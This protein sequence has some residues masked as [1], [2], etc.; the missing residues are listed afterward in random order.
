M[1][2]AGSKP[3]ERLALIAIAALALMW[4]AAVNGGPF[5]TT[6]SI[7]YIR[8]PDQAV[9]KLFG[10]GHA[11]AWSAKPMGMGFHRGAVASS[12]KDEGKTPPMAGR[13]IYYGLLANLG[14]RAGGFWLTIALQA[15]ATAFA[16]S[17]LCRS[18]GWE[19]A[20]SYQGVAALATP[21]H[22]PRLLRLLHHAGCLGADPD[23][24][25]RGAGGRWRAPVAW[26][27]A[28]AVLTAAPGLRGRRAHATH[29]LLLAAIAGAG[30]ILIGSRGRLRLRLG[31]AGLMAGA[32]LLALS[33]GA[34]SL[35]AF[36]V[37]VTRVY[38]AP[39]VQPPVPDRA[40][41]LATHG[42]ARLGW[43]C[44]ARP[45]GF[46]ACAY[47]GR[48][49]M[50][51]DDF[52]WSTLPGRSA[53]WTA[54]APA[55]RAALGDEQFRFAAAVL[56]DDPLGVVRQFTADGASPVRRHHLGGLQSARTACG[57]RWKTG[58][59][60]PTPRSGA[61]AWPIAKPGRLAC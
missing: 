37:A 32:A 4:P 43:T 12:A 45:S 5:F 47:V 6:D 59:S 10:P 7:A 60:D 13:S 1:R 61:P 8:G 55:Q 21:D 38:H 58:W 41:E 39:P 11:T 53:F 22:A 33:I 24:G 14:A 52:L 50:S 17:L 40:A 51:T 2:M 29:I 27:R 36:S 20:S 44:I 49:P 3:L 31:A 15:L 19:R 57:L 18:L 54:D 42:R 9:V 30:L 56:Q 16:L 48:L 26:Q 34:A 25:L 23:P 35:I 28:G 46:Q